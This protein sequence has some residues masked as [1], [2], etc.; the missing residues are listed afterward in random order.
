[1]QHLII[2]FPLI[3]PYL[4][5]FTPITIINK[6]VLVNDT[7]FTIKIN[8]TNHF[9]KNHAQPKQDIFYETEVVIVTRC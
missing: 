1:M 8:T 3:N 2:F 9:I 6:G 4:L 5:N 7:N